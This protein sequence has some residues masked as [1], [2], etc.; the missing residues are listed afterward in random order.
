MD[1]TKSLIST[2]PK[3]HKCI[4]AMQIWKSYL[5]GLLCLRSLCN[6]EE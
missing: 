5:F 2:I 4:A 3:K 1:S 6:A